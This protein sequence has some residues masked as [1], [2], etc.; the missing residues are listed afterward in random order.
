M[1]F[2]ISWKMY[3]DKKMDCNKIFSQMTPE[4]DLKDA[5]ESIKIIG[6]WHAVGGGRGTCICETDSAESLTG[7][8]VNWAEMCELDVHPVVDDSTVRSVLSSKLNS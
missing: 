7:W 3:P 5:G 4:D 8:M 6:R 2:Q 1:L